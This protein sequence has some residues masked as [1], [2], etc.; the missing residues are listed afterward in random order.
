MTYGEVMDSSVN[1]INNQT[2]DQPTFIPP[3]YSIVR[4]LG[5]GQTSHVYLANHMRLGE[6]ALKLPRDELYHRPVLRRMFENEVQITLSIK[7]DEHIVQ[8]FEGFPT[9]KNAFLALQYCPGG[10]L[11]QL[12]LEQGKLPL[13]QS[14]QLILDVAMGV[15]HAHS[16]KVLHRDVKPANVFLTEVKR[17]KLGD[18]G[19]GVFITEQSID[20]RVG[21]AFYMAPEVFEGKPPTIQSDMYSLGVLTYEVL[22]GTRPFNGES[23]DQLMM[24]HLTSFPDPIRKYR[25]NLSMEISQVVAQAMSR[26]ASRRFQNVDMFIVA[27]SKATGIRPLS[28]ASEEQLQTGRSTQIIR[29]VTPVPGKPPASNKSSTKES[30]KGGLFSWFRKKN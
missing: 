20:E 8:A 28:Y 18:F 12:L 22:A 1:D 5:S 9:G 29:P 27:F 7:E 23:Y 6:L 3:G 10:T 17:A 30:P 11:D 21:T 25:S 26:D 19:T 13:D 15:A 14:V 16:K 24:Q 2:P 4:K